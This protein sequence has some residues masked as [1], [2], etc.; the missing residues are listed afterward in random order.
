MSDWDAVAVPV[1]YVGTSYLG[2]SEIGFISIV[3]CC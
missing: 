2:Q 3:S 1:W